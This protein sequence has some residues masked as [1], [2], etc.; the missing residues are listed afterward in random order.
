MCPVVANKSAQ[1]KQ[2]FCLLF[3]VESFISFSV[4]I[5]K[6]DSKTNSDCAKKSLFGLFYRSLIRPLSC[7]GKMFSDKM[8]FSR[9][10]FG[11]PFPM[12]FISPIFSIL[13]SKFVTR[14]ISI[15]NYAA[16]VIKMQ[17]CHKTSVMSSR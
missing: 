12:V 16:T 13:K 5:S 8:L 4:T 11:C 3:N 17:M 9:I 10:R 15:P 7:M 6:K 1:K 14:F 2:L